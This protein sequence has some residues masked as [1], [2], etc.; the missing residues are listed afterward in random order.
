MTDAD[1]L[2]FIVNVAVYATKAVNILAMQIDKLDL[3]DDHTVECLHEE[4]CRV[5]QAAEQTGN[6]QLVK[7][8]STIGLLLPSSGAGSRQH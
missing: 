5:R 1:M 6:E 4:Y 7:A 3:L 8:V 2:E